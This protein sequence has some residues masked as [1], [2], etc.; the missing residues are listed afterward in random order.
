MTTTK[1]KVPEREDVSPNNQV[2]FDNLKKAL[3]F[4]PNLYATIAYSDTGLENYLNFQNGKTSLSKKEKEA[5]NLVVSQI[6]NCEYCLSAHT[7]LGKM[8]GFTEEQTIELRKG[9]ASF[10]SK[11]DALVKF[12]NEATVNKGKVSEPTLANFFKAGYGEASIIDVHIAIAEKVVMN[13]IHNLTQI[14]IDFP[15]AKPLN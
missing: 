2:I 11:L 6:N 3:G 10:D 8:N 1:F 4:V 5:I 15:L 14:P 7:L 9:S 13:Y 12:T